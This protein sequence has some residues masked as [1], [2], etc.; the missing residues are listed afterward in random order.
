METLMPRG[1]RG[2]NRPADVI[3]SRRVMRIA[4]GEKREELERATP[5]PSWA[6]AAGSHAPNSSPG[7]RVMAEEL[8][9][10]F[11][12]MVWCGE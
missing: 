2:E 5:P 10:G 7:D 3:G 1:P 9:R 6:S 8:H 11:R 12:I 4:T